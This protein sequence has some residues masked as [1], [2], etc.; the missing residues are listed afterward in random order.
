[1][2]RLFFILS[3][4]SLMAPAVYAAR[5]ASNYYNE[6]MSLYNA[7]RLSEATDAFETA[8]KKKDRPAEAQR[9]IDRIRKETVE[10]IRNRALTGVS[11]TTWQNKYF[12][13]RAVGGRLRVGISSQEI[14]DRQSLNFREGAVDALVQLAEVLQKNDNAVADIDLISE[15][16]TD[17]VPNPDLLARHEAELFSFLALAAQD[18]LPKY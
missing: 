6:G 11:K 5:A 14:F 8:I 10:R 16:N 13:I 7:G 3:V 12:F 15:I 1:M 18:L 17:T 4:C 2:K 9:F